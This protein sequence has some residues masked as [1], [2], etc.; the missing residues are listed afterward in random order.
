MMNDLYTARCIHFTFFSRG[1]IQRYCLKLNH[2]SR[3][4]QQC[5]LPCHLETPTYPLVHLLCSSSCSGMFFVFFSSSSS[6]FTFFPSLFHT[7]SYHF[8]YP[9]LL[10]IIFL[11]LFFSLLLL[12]LLLLLLPSSFSSFSS[13]PFFFLFFFILIFNISITIILN[14]I[15]FVAVS[16]SHPIQSVEHLVIIITCLFGHSETVQRYWVWVKDYCM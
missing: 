13:S 16:L 8:Y 14:F 15:T 3:W 5:F 12:L 1:N 9:L 6:I 11:F 7:Y 2:Y 4:Y 10:V